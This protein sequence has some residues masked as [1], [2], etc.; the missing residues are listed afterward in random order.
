MVTTSHQILSE[1]E[2]NSI[3]TRHISFTSMD[4]KFTHDTLY[5]WGWGIVVSPSY[6]TRGDNVDATPTINYNLTIL[7]TNFSET[8]KNWSSTSVIIFL[9]LSHGASYYTQIAGNPVYIV[10]RQWV[11]AQNASQGGS[12]INIKIFQESPSRS[13]TILS[14]SSWSPSEWDSMIN[15]LALLDHCAETWPNPRHL[16]HWVCWMDLDGSH[17]I[18][19]P[20]SSRLRMELLTQNETEKDRIET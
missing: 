5:G 7:T 1:Y 10:N 8:L 4:A 12:L 3:R 15:I 17:A 14:K 19:L 11:H 6:H 2:A 9:E 18:P 13:W 20:L 16:K